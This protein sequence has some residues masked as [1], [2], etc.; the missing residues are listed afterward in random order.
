[1]YDYNLTLAGARIVEVGDKRGTTEKDMASAINELTAAVVYFVFDPEEGVL[2]LEDVIRIAHSSG[3]PVIVDAA[4]ENPPAENLRKFTSMGADLVVFSGG[5]DIGAMN[6]S[7]LLLGRKDLVQTCVRLGPHSYE[8]SESG[9]RVY[10]GRPM[11]VSKEAIVG[12]VAAVK[13][14]LRTDQSARLREWDKKAD[15]LLAELSGC[16]GVMVRKV[17]P[18]N[19]D[20]PR[21]MIV[22]RVEIEPS[23]PKLSA[24]DLEKELRKGSLPIHAYSLE[25]KLYINPQCLLDGD[26]MIVAKRLRELLEDIALKN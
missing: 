8:Q 5:K 6:N 9:L 18:V 15:Y 25:G 13:R 14:Y 17:L 4:A 23:S 24:E 21:P 26:E 2:P 7:G 19:I 22:P 1:M 16:K 11:K 10:I 20:H 3:I 12:L